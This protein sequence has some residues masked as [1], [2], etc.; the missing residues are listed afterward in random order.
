MP[1]NGIELAGILVH[2]Y[3]MRIKKT[4]CSLLVFFLLALL[5]D[6]TFVSCASRGA[7]SGGD[8]DTLAPKV[9]TTFPPNFTTE[10]NSP[11]VEIL[12]NEYISLKSANQQISITPPLSE[13]L[14]ID[15]GSKSIRI[16]L[17]VDSLLPNTTYTISFGSSIT[18]F[19]EGNINGRFKYVFSTGTYIDSLSLKGQIRNKEG[20]PQPEMLLALYDYTTLKRKD[21]IPFYNLPTYYTYTDEE[22]AFTLTNL[23]YGKFH[24]VGFTD[25][26]GRFKMQTGQ[27]TTAFSKDTLVLDTNT[28]ALQLLAF[29]PENKQRFISARHV[30]EGKIRMIFS[31]DKRDVVVERLNLTNGKKA[32]EDYL[33]RSSSDT[34]FYWFQLATD[35]VVLRINKP[36]V[37]DD[38]AVVKLREFSPQKLRLSLKEKELVPGG[39]LEVNTNIP[40]LTLSK[41]GFLV[42]TKTD[43]I[44]DLTIVAADSSK[45]A[46]YIKTPPRGEKTELVVL[47][48]ALTPF[49]GVQNDTVQFSYTTLAKEALGNALFKVVADSNNRYILNLFTPEDKLVLSR[50]FTGSI[51]LDLK[52]L[53]P[54]K[55]KAQ[56][57]IDRDKNGRWSSGNYLRGIQPERIIN[58][59]EALEIRANWDVEIEWLLS[60]DQLRSVN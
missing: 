50:S 44:R 16:K 20:A 15:A 13:K 2:N 54:K 14:D 51:R 30:S 10:F 3:T 40:F 23:K 8:K 9:D 43:T 17:L 59:V 32:A 49:T 35:S 4:G 29:E 46:F 45:K 47:P 48:N 37:Y 1:N 27:E 18:D 12:F 39:A 11:E 55:Y 22:G 42:Y 28:T 31:G 5:A 24:V 34:L 19:T 36:G 41:D 53:Y 38:T 33:E 21:S 57:V 52:N 25:K 56:L 26:G 6:L 7:P 58:Y 60:E